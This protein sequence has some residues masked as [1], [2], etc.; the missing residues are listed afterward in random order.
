LLWQD[1][2]IWL[3]DERG[4]AL[5]KQII[6]SADSVCSNI[7]EGYGRGYGKQYLQFYGYSLGS[8]RET[9][10]RLYRAKAFYPQ[11]TL[12]KR[13]QLA[14]EVVALVLTEINRQKGR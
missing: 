4:Q 7:E 9:K 8:A 10:G 1:T 11:D 2:E 5:S 14:S 12:F 13:M 6:A 3:K